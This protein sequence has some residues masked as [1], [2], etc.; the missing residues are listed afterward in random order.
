MEQGK[1][2][3]ESEFDCECGGETQHLFTTEDE[4]SVYR[5]FKCRKCGDV[6]NTDSRK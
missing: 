1:N 3:S 5:F 6:I 2:H 4:D